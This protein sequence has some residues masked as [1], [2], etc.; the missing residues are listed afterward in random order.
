[1]SEPSSDHP[2]L[3]GLESELD[4]LWGFALHLA[5][6]SDDAADLVQRTC[7]HA[8]EQ[9]HRYDPA[10]PLR[11][12]LF[13]MARNLWLNEVR[14]R[15]TS[16]RVLGQ[17]VHEDHFATEPRQSAPRV[18]TRSAPETSALLVDVERAVAALP[19][20][21][22]HVL[23][24]V[25]VEGLSYR[26]TAD[27]LDVPIGTVMSRLARARLAIGRRFTDQQAEPPATSRASVTPLSN[28]RHKRQDA[29]S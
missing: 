24:L 20:A 23:V 29:R 8:I 9:R 16:R 28:R 10:R 25:A 7:A 22:R 17:L 18:D 26:E 3:V 2:V 6:H 15:E 27:V 21:Q 1:M 4:R 19:D 12:W 13:R 14:S 11:N 5:R